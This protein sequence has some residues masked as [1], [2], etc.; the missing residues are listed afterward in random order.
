MACEECVILQR[1][2][3]QCQLN[4]LEGKNTFYDL[5]MFYYFRLTFLLMHINVFFGIGA[6]PFFCDGILIIQCNLPR[7]LPVLILKYA[8][9]LIPYFDLFLCGEWSNFVFKDFQTYFLGQT[10]FCLPP[11]L[12]DF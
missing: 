10:F 7:V 4:W 12:F 8:S 2:R 3:R 5:N 11:L 6:M 9:C 1:E